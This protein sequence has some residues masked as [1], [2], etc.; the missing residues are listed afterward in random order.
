MY[1]TKL[2]SRYGPLNRAIWEIEQPACPGQTSPTMDQDVPDK[3]LYSW[4]GPINRATGD[5]E[6]P[7][8]PGQTSPTRGWLAQLQARETSPDGSMNR[9][10]GYWRYRTTKIFK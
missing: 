10:T 2:Y 4:A 3:T 5:I 9:N 8:C 1:Q 6:Q 7:T